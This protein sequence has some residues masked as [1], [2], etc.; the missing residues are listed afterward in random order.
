MKRICILTLGLMLLTGC[1]TPLFRSVTTVLGSGLGA[2]AG[3]VVGKG[4]PEFAAGGAALGAAGSEI[5]HHA[6]SRAE[7]KA[8]RAGYEQALGDQSRAE[9]QRLQDQHRPVT[10]SVLRLPVPV[11]EHLSPDGVRRQATTRLVEIHQ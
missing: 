9:Y 8:F 5:L 1:G 2:A 4:K 3:N 11:P 10:P 7:Q 6:R